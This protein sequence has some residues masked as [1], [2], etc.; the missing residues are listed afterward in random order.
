MNLTFTGLLIASYFL[1][2]PICANTFHKYLGYDLSFHNFRISHSYSTFLYSNSFINNNNCNIIQNCHFSSF[3]NRVLF[4][5]NIRNSPNYYSNK[6][7]ANPLN[8]TS[9][10]QNNLR[11]SLS[12]S[13]IIE[14]CLFHS[15][16]GQQSGGCIYTNEHLSVTNSK[17]IKCNAHTGGCIYIV[18]SS[19]AFYSNLIQSCESNRMCPCFYQISEDG[20]NSSLNIL[21]TSFEN[22]YSKDL[23]GVFYRKSSNNFLMTNSNIT[24]CGAK[25]CVGS[26]EIA[27]SPLSI[28][29]CHIFKSYAKV[30]NG[31]LVCRDNEAFSIEFTSFIKCEHRSFVSEAGSI[32]LLY[33]APSNS[34]IHYISVIDSQFAD[35]FSITVLY[36]YA[37]DFNH[38]YFSFPKEK[39]INPISVNFC[40]FSNT[41]FNCYRCEKSNKEINDVINKSYKNQNLIY[42]NIFNGQFDEGFLNKIF[43]YEF[44]INSFSHNWIEIL[45]KTF[46]VSKKIIVFGILYIVFLVI[47]FILLIMFNWMMIKYPTLCVIHRK[48]GFELFKTPKANL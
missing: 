9:Y 33:G 16:S 3:L 14:N 47:G 15:I 10:N 48:V 35:S 46:G 31:C 25:N 1:N 18:D 43:N 22:C 26:F 5:N 39:E 28:N 24:N 36:G 17:F 23:F 44:Q 29:F 7:F 2:S 32:M 37:I 42:Q 30:H 19:L 34:K 45:M 41:Q 20:R 12:N 8:I 11:F 6:N 38:C 27:M 13:I 4:L 40:F 21:F